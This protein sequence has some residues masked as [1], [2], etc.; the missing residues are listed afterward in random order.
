MP[1]TTWVEALDEAKSALRMAVE[2][3]TPEA[4]DSKTRVAYGWMDI[5]RMLADHD[6]V[7]VVGQQ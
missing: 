3:G 2:A 4:T 1:E 7:T 6:G 5:A